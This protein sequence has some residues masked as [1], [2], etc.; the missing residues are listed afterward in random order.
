MSCLVTLC[1]SRQFVNIKAKKV[2]KKSFLEKF[3]AGVE[4]VE[5]YFLLVWNPVLD[6]SAL[7]SQFVSQ[8]LL[9]LCSL[10]PQSINGQAQLSWWSCL[11]GN[12]NSLFPNIH[13]GL[14]ICAG[15]FYRSTSALHHTTSAITNS[16][17][18]NKYTAMQM[19]GYVGLQTQRKTLN[20]LLGVL[21][22]STH[23]CK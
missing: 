5:T 7:S 20:V 4:F 21:N 1:M 23:L 11:G 9:F 16:I 2:S 13:S 12:H 15:M 3:W 17:M 14:N 18:L 8:L 22:S 10:L 19:E 6:F